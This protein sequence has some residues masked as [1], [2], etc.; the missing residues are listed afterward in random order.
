MNKVNY[1]DDSPIT[2]H[3]TT[4][5]LSAL[6]LVRCSGKGSLE[7]AASVF[8]SP[9]K[10]LKTKGNT[11][12]H[13]WIV[14][15]NSGKKNGSEQQPVDEVLISVFRAPKSYTGEDSLDICCHG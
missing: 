15:S 5:G 9:E 13:G 2:A 3:A 7:L 11:V 14:S 10:L 6:S 1:G 8:S 4:P 12:I